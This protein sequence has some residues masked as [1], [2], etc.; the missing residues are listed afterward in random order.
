MTRK[1]IIVRL[2]LKIFVY[3]VVYNLVLLISVLRRQDEAVRVYSTVSEA[4]ALRITSSVCRLGRGD[5]M[6]TN[7]PL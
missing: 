4:N 5:A 7:H 3:L 2:L 6:F 1:S